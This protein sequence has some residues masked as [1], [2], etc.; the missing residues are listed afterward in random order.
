MI[1][2]RNPFAL[3]LKQGLAANINA[4]ATK[5]M[6]MLGEPAYTTDTKIMYIFDG[7]QFVPVVAMYPFVVKTDDYT[8]T[9]TDRVIVCDKA[10]AMTITLPA[11]TGS[12]HIYNIANVGAGDVTIDANASETINGATTQTV[13]QYAAMTVCDYASG[14]WVVL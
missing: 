8:A 6:A 1:L 14:A 10:T 11:A 4:T 9:V 7:S 5:L 3:K 12:G 13:I 2:N